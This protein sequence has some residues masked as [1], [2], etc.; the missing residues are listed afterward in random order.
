MPYIVAITQDCISILKNLCITMLNT[1]WHACPQ[2]AAFL[3]W[4][5][6]IMPFTYVYT[7]FQASTLSS[8]WVSL[9]QILCPYCLLTMHLE[10]CAFSGSP[11]WSVMG[12]TKWPATY[13]QYFALGIQLPLA[14]QSPL[15]FPLG[16]WL[17]SK[18]KK[19]KKEVD[20]SLSSKFWPP[21]LGFHQADVGRTN[22]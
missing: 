8:Q 21:H 9:S 4:S 7:S 22:G 2:P 18:N 12:R 1:G 3:S 15:F 19:K 6:C 13:T 11:Q 16:V 5:T 10:A 20:L 17:C 14:L